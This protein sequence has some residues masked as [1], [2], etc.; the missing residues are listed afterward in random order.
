MEAI[1]W[2]EIQPEDAVDIVLPSPDIIGPTNEFGE[3]CPWPWE[4]QQLK[5]QPLGMYHCSYCGGMVVAG[6]PHTDYTDQHHEDR[7]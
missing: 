2:T 5:G 3:P 4:P 6:I 1:N 7:P